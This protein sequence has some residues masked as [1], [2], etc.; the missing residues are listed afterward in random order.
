MSEYSPRE[1][2]LIT[3][4]RK[5]E[6]LEVVKLIEKFVRPTTLSDG[7]IVSEIKVPANHLISLINARGDATDHVLSGISVD[8]TVLPE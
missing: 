2:D 5:D 6:R 7:D 1:I 8:P 4:A 3:Q